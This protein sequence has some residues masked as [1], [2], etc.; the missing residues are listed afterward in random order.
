MSTVTVIWAIFELNFVTTEM[1]LPG[2]NM[3]PSC[4]RNCAIRTSTI[5][6]GKLNNCK[7][8]TT[9][10]CEETSPEIFNINTTMNKHTASTLV[11]ILTAIYFALSCVEARNLYLLNIKT[12]TER[13]NKGFGPLLA[14]AVKVNTIGCNAIGFNVIGMHDIRV[15]LLIWVEFKKFLNHL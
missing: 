8:K 15:T 2:F 13:G 12:K 6:N 7:G 10:D 4:F 9:A 14:W 1:N 3:Y 11:F 5:T